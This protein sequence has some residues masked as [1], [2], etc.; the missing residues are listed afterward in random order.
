VIC[1]RF[2]YTVEVEVLSSETPALRATHK[3]TINVLAPK[4]T[5][6]LG[7]WRLGYSYGPELGE[8]SYD[9]VVVEAKGELHDEDNAPGTCKYAGGELTFTLE[10]APGAVFEYKGSGAGSSGPFSG[11]W[12]S[13]GKLEKAF[14]F[15]RG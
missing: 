10:V 12:G 13:P 7:S 3:Y 14:I 6:A 2:Q 4:A 8:P 5:L 11:L 15:E 1:D 9:G